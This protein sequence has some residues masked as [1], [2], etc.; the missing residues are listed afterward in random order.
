VVVFET[1]VA[2]DNNGY[3]DPL[4]VARRGVCV[5]GRGHSSDGGDRSCRDSLWTS[6][7]GAAACDR[8]DQSDGDRDCEHVEEVG[9]SEAVEL[10]V[11]LAESSE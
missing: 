10:I 8:C 4:A 7:S 2:A 5:G 3:A 11:D 1:F 6:R 9:Q